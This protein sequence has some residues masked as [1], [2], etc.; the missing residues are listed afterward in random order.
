M[1]DES[2]GVNVG[3]EAVGKL[4]GFRFSPDERAEGIH[5]RTLRAAA[6]K[7]L[8]GEFA[9]RERRL[10]E[11]EARDITLSEH[12]RIWWDG[13]IVARLIAGADPLAPGLALEADEHLTAETRARL[14]AKLTRWLADAYCR[15][16]RKP[17]GA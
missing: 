15:P 14:T 12:G 1:L 5:G 16:A 7:A 11:A 3:G 6:L 8:E 2:G 10:L 4:E 9:R 13:A 17:S